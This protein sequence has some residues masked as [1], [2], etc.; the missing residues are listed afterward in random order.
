MR[1][2]GTSLAGQAIG[3]GVVLDVSRLDRILSL[4]PD[5][6]I[7]R[8][9]PGVVQADLDAAAREH[10]LCFGPDT[11]TATRATIGGMVGNDSAGMRSVVYGRTSHRIR[12]L[13]VLLADGTEQWVG[14]ADAATLD[15]PVRGRA[16]GARRAGGG[17]RARAGRSCCAA[18]TATTCRR[19]RATGRTSRGSCA[20]PRARWRWCS[21][22]RSSSTRCP[23][24]RSW[25]IVRLAL[26][27]RD[28][29]RLAGG[30][31]VGADGG[32]DRRC[33][34]HRRQRGGARHLGRRRRGAAGR[35]LRHAPTEVRAARSV[36][37]GADIP[38]AA[39][40]VH[41]RGARGERAHRPLPPRHAGHDQPRRARQPP[42]DHGGRGRRGA[43][44][45]ARRVP[46]RP[47][48]GVPRR[49][50]GV[51]HLRPRVGR[52]R[53]RAAAARPVRRGGPQA[54]PPPGRAR[55][56][57]AD[58]ARR[59]AVGRARR[60]HPPRRAAAAPVRRRR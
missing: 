6:R 58:R 49:G 31:A 21:R 52:L 11:A 7:A 35:A 24:E 29:R 1:G 47:P 59:R 25:T 45:A 13:R 2:A 60:R 38:G 4:D 54:L 30:A 12:R 17:D 50:H 34:R 37:A 57:P 42:P 3:A 39:G 44:R 36:L 5:E 14:E 22:S 41:G 23:T 20:A 9:E 43:G 15:G 55:R 28:R 48:S 19:W 27:R 56:R 46:D 40:V 26:A 16:R 33:R 53:A 8:V 18:S 51:R 10:G 32:R